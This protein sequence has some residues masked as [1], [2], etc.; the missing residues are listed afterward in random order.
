MKC[1]GLHCNIIKNFQKKN[2]V[3]KISNKNSQL[4]VN[5]N[6]IGICAECPEV[7]NEGRLCGVL[8]MC[9]EFYLP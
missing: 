1:V 8:C 2:T 3:K 5:V 7:I 4:F 6:V 9:I